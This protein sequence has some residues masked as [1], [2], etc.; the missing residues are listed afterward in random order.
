[1]ALHFPHRSNV[2]GMNDNVTL[3]F[4]LR[5]YNTLPNI[6][7]YTKDAPSQNKPQDQLNHWQ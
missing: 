4:N 2:V 6:T 7:G 3:D 1:M 5:W